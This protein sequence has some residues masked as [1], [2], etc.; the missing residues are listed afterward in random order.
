MHTAE[1]AFGSLCG[2]PFFVLAYFLFLEGTRM[3]CYCVLHLKT[4]LTTDSGNK[5]EDWQ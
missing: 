1:T 5:P 4:T 2:C 3:I